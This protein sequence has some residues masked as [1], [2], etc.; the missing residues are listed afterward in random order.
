[1][2]KTN[3]IMESIGVMGRNRMRQCGHTYALIQAMRIDPKIKMI[4]ARHIQ[5]RQLAEQYDLHKY[6]FI[7]LEELPRMGERCPL[8]YD[9]TAIRQMLFCALLETTAAQEKLTRTLNKM[10]GVIDE[11][12]TA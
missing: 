7:C 2:S 4:V 8:V 5:V 1:M 6:R 9:H 10:Q 12:Q 11:M 3:G